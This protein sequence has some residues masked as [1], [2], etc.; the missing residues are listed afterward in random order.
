VKKYVDHKMCF[1][2]IYCVCLKYF[3]LQ[4]EFSKMLWYMYIGL[5][6]KYPL[7]LSD[8]NKTWLLSTDFRKILKYQ[9][10]WKSV[11]WEPRC[12]MRTDRRT[13]RRTEDGQTDGGRTDGRRT[14]RQTD[15]HD[16]A[17]SR[18]S[19]FCERA[20][21]RTLCPHSVFVWFLCISVQIVTISLYSSNCFY[22][23]STVCLLRGP[24]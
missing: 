24:R 2:F 3:S 20:L 4:E 23:R 10:S 9:I 16:E 7:F 6:V 11:H 8:F 12:S 18:F 21:N 13:D 22:N 17:S 14:E 5:S 15:S 19:Q 1:D